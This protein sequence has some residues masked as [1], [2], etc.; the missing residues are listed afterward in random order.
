VA[1]PAPWRGHAGQVSLDWHWQWDYGGG[2]LG[3]Q[4]IHQM[5]LA[6]WPWRK[7]IEPPRPQ[8][9]RSFGGADAGETPDTQV[10]IHDYGQDAVFEVADWRPTV[11]TDSRRLDRRGTGG[12]LVMT[13]YD[14]GAAFDTAGKKLQEFSGGG[15]FRQLP[16]AVRSRNV[17][18]LHAD[19]EEGHLSSALCTW[20]T[21][22]TDW[23][24][25]RPGATR[26]AG[27]PVAGHVR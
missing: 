3:N 6:R 4:G 12:Y 23:R 15:S 26:G 20:A 10:V 5:D 1:R 27:P 11:A 7:P 24:L 13:S 21:R 2:D 14:R 16:Q 8:L 19:I 22:R 17:R 18:D 9:R 25:D